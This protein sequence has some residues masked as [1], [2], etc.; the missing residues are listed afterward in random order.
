MPTIF[1]EIFNKQIILNSKTIKDFITAL[2]TLFNQLKQ[3]SD[4]DNLKVLRNRLESLLEDKSRKADKKMKKVLKPLYDILEEIDD[5]IDE[6]ANKKHK[7]I[8]LVDVVKK[9]EDRYKECKEIP[10]H[11]K[12]KYTQACIKKETISY[13]KELIKLQVELLK[14]QKYI[15]E[16]N[17]KLLIIFE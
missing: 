4:I 17:E 2:K 15:K 16:N 7:T 1:Y 13:E 6:T 8:Q 10:E 3:D 14:L 5:C 12:D 9:V 11:K